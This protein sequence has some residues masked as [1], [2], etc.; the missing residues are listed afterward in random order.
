MRIP[1]NEL[2][3]IQSIV[4]ATIHNIYEYKNSVLGVL[5]AVEN[6]YSDL[7]TEVEDVQTKLTNGTGI[8][9]LKEVMDKL[10]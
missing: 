8:A 10:G 9:F 3:A 4:E 1:E 6:D 2:G 5:Q 7:N